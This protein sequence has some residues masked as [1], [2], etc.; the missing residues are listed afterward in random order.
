NKNRIKSFQ[1]ICLIAFLFLSF[2][3]LIRAENI[4]WGIRKLLYFLSVFPIYFLIINVFDLDKLKN[5]KQIK[6]IIIVFIGGGFLIALIGLIQFLSQFVFGLES[7]YGFWAVNIVP[8]FSGFNYGSLILAYSSWLVNLN[9]ATVMRAFSI[10]SDPH[11]FSFYL[12]MLLPFMIIVIMIINRKLFLKNIFLFLSVICYLCLLLSFSRGAYFAIISAFFTMCFLLWKYLGNKKI[13]IILFLLLLILVIPGTSFSSRFYS[14]FNINEKSN[15]GRLEMWMR[16]GK[17]GWQNPALG[18]GLGNYSLSIDDKSDYRNPIT[19][20]NLY[21]D[22][23][24][25]IGLIALVIWISL[26]IGTIWQLFLKLKKSEK[27]EQY[28]IIGLIGS[29]VYF[30][31]HSIFETT[32]YSPVILAV[33]MA[34]FGISTIICKN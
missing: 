20:H 6:K 19:A 14:S 27:E 17:A 29:L 23:F 22:F 28:I 26:I 24:S 1:N 34:I 30:S 4:I 5:I 32:V 12:G 31:T 8:V 3:S 11:I 2:F 15:S 13:P 33:L 16:A 25:E 10:F 21:L 18:I 9:G 7:V